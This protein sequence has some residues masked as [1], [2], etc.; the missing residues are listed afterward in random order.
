MSR[1]KPWRPAYLVY[2][3][4]DYDFSLNEVNVNTYQWACYMIDGYIRNLINGE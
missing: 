3:P 2:H 4:S 1:L